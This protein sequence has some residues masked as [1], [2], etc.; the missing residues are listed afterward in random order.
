MGTTTDATSAAQFAAELRANVE[1]WYA[2][3]NTP[4]NYAAFSARNGATWRKVLD[5]GG[6]V[7]EEVLRILRERR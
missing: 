3:P 4:A 5:A 1:A 6:A 2:Q 7:E